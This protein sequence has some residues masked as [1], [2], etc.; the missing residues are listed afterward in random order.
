MIASFMRASYMLVFH[1]SKC[2]GMIK[3]RGR[4][5][6]VGLGAQSSLLI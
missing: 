3:R 5:G 2:F 6:T 1:Q 4:W